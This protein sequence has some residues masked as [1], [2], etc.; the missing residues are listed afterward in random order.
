MFVEIVESFFLA[1]VEWAWHE[2]PRTAQSFTTDD[3]FEL[4][5][6]LIEFN[7]WHREARLGGNL[8]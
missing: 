8:F 4:H 2:L 3:G 1:A 6:Q 7:D 5:F